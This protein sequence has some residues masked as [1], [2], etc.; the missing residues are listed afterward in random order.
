MKAGQHL[1]RYSICTAKTS[2]E[3]V[4]AEALH[5]NAAVYPFVMVRNAIFMKATEVTT[6]LV[7][8]SAVSHDIDFEMS[9]PL[10]IH[11]KTANVVFA[12]TFHGRGIRTVSKY[13]CIYT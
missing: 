10:Y 4:Y 9:G 2:Q 1:L 13:T 6:V 11:F 7:N 5:E 8:K 12:V 3:K